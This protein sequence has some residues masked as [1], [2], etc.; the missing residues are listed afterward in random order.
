MQ[1]VQTVQTALHARDHVPLDEFRCIF[2]IEKLEIR[3]EPNSR[4][5]SEFRSSQFHRPTFSIEPKVVLR[6]VS[7]PVSVLHSLDG[8]MGCCGCGV[9]QLWR[10]FS[11]VHLSRVVQMV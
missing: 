9:L 6:A 4:K 5:T 11:V 8:S 3:S 2:S 10:A 1:T 7:G